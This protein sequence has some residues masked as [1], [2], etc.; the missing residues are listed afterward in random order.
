ML[1]KCFLTS[2]SVMEGF[3][4]IVVTVIFLVLVMFVL[5]GSR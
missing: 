2:K 1:A 3:S 4:V 5:I